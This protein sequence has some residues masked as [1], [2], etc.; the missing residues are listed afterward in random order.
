LSYKEIRERCFLTE[1][2]K[3]TEEYLNIFFV[4]SVNFVRNTFSPSSQSPL[5]FIEA[6][7]FSSES[8]VYFFFA[9]SILFTALASVPELRA[10]SWK[11]TRLKEGKMDFPEDNP[12]VYQEH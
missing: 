7:A 9:L 3:Y 10:S 5:K 2:T 6:K 4:D 8:F 11:E 1:Y 12:L